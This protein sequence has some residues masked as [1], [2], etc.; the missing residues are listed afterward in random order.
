ML[1]DYLHYTKTGGGGGGGGGCAFQIKAGIFST[2]LGKGPRAFCFG[3]F[4]AFNRNWEIF[5]I[6]FYSIFLNR[7]AL[8]A[9]NH[10]YF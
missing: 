7:D 10:S 5:F 2:F 6:H 1:G 3:K 4:S 9:L 8:T